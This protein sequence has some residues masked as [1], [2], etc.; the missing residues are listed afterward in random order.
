M[1]KIP[2][3]NTVN[4]VMTNLAH[5][6]EQIIETCTGHIELPEHRCWTGIYTWKDENIQCEYPKNVFALE[7]PHDGG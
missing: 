7:G 2:K 5:I 6:R 4:G 3:Q 1:H